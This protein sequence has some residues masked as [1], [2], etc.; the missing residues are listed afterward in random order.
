VAAADELV[1]GSLDAG[2]GTGTWRSGGRRGPDARRAQAQLLLVIV[3]LVHARQR[4]NPQAVAEEAQRLRAV[5]EAPETAQPGLGQGLRALALVSL[6]STEVW[7]TRLKEA[8]RHLEQG[9][10]LARRIDRPSG[11]SATTRAR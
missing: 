4:A 11:C 1:H 9:V 5:A 10:A 6:G 2:S 3:R 8:E 7:T